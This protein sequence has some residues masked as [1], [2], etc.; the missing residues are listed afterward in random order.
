[1]ARGLSGALDFH[2]LSSPPVMNPK[3]E[4]EAMPNRRNV[5]SRLMISR[6]TDCISCRLSESVV[7]LGAEGSEW[8]GPEGTGVALMGADVVAD[9]LRGVGFDVVAELAGEEVTG[10]DAPAQL[11]PPLGGVPRLP[12]LGWR[13]GWRYAGG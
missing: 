6:N 11:A 7:T 12:V 2:F 5:A 13:R 9:E 10:E 8:A 1:M 4:G 3:G